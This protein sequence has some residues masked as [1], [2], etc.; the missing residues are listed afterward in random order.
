MPSSSLPISY[1]SMI[2]NQFLLHDW[3]LLL[4]LHLPFFSIYFAFY[5]YLFFSNSFPEFILVIAS[6]FIRFQ[7]SVTLN[8][9]NT[10]RQAR[11]GPNGTTAGARRDPTQQ[12]NLSNDPR[13]IGQQQ[14]F[15]QLIFT[16]NCLK[17]LYCKISHGKIY[18]IGLNITQVIMYNSR[19]IAHV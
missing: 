1:D 14:T 3:D 12:R 15:Q 13:H 6:I 17:V 10:G 18:M 16:T 19:T 11:G 9:C 5:F 8:S 2:Q 4:K 7:F